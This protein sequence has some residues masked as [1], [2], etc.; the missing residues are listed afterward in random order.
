MKKM[1]EKIWKAEMPIR[2]EGNNHAQSIG[3]EIIAPRVL[4][5]NILEKKICRT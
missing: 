2:A 3:L 1:E 5:S 4:L